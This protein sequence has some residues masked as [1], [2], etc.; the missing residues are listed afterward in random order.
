LSHKGVN[1]TR[2]GIQFAE[3]TPPWH[4]LLTNRNRPWA[5]AVPPHLA[6]R[7][8]RGEA[9]ACKGTHLLPQLGCR[10][11]CTTIAGLQRRVRV[12]VVISGM[13]VPDR[14]QDG[15]CQASPVEAAELLLR[16][17]IAGAGS[18]FVLN[19]G[20]WYP[21]EQRAAQL[22]AA[23]RALSSAMG[24]PERP[25]GA[26][27]R[28]GQLRVFWRETSPQAF[29]GEADGSWNHSKKGWYHRQASGCEAVRKA[30]RPPGAE[31]LLDDLEASGVP[32][33]RVWE[34]SVTQ[35]DAHLGDI[36]GR[37]KHAGSTGDG[38]HRGVDCT[39]YCEPSGVLE[40]WV[41]LLLLAIARGH[42]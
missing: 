13:V 15:V 40:A 28:G 31:R 4:A 41:D 5:E 2:R 39:H 17:G 34:A 7:C 23:T 20:L 19:E 22:A 37:L 24:D 8:A 30:R 12:C 26:L 9:A 32:V 25:M 33:L 36:G 14:P 16:L 27:A 18:T 38:I 11:S 29:P 10:P 42:G 35:W 3:Q 21:P 6:A 1:T